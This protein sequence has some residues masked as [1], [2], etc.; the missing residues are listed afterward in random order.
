[1]NLKNKITLTVVIVFLIVVSF[2]GVTYLTAVRTNLDIKADE[3]A[4]EQCIE[5]ANVLSN[6]FNVRFVS[7]N[8]AAQDL[9][10]RSRM[11]AADGRIPILQYALRI[12]GFEYY[13]LQWNEQWYQV[14]YDNYIERT[15]EYDLSD[16]SGKVVYGRMYKAE[17]EGLLFVKAL[18]DLN[19]HTNGLLVAKARA[20]WD[21]I[22]ATESL[23]NSHL[24][25]SKPSGEIIYS[26][27][28]QDGHIYIDEMEKTGSIKIISKGKIINTKG[29]SMGIPNTT[30]NVTVIVDYDSVVAE[31]RKS[32]SYYI[33]IALLG[34]LIVGVIVYFVVYRLSR[35]ITELAAYVAQMGTELESLPEKFTKR[36]DEA[37]IL[38]QSFSLLFNRLKSALDE[39]DY[40]ACHDSLTR[41]KNRY[42]LEQTTAKLI[43][44]N[45]PFAF[46]LLDVDDF[47]IINDTLGH[48]E[49]DRQLENLARI[50]MAFDPH[51]LVAYR[52]GGDEFALLIYGSSFQENNDIMKK[53]M[54]RITAGIQ[55][56]ENKHLT[57]SIGVCTFPDCAQ[58]YKELLIAA[59]KALAWAKMSGKVNFCFYRK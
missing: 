3:Y 29:A 33:A 31:F 56:N 57:V 18:E 21:D 37:G 50:F 26:A 39:K 24:I 7:V 41:L 12:S 15:P 48:D 52:W 2:I 9:S 59:D 58:T 54:D 27:E 16:M 55:T 30:L 23:N 25:L 32:V 20:L 28:H 49:G 43:Q 42:C 47:K 51:E 6:Y 5:S 22:A 14:T 53:V 19:G 4:A 46:G 45:K 11:R 36:S 44:E 35:S 40:M 38:S 1:M 8:S 13:A 17:D 34:E 10:E